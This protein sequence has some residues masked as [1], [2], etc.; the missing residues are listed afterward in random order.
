[1]VW[2][3]VSNQKVSKRSV[4]V[5]ATEILFPKFCHLYDDVTVQLKGSHVIG[6]ALDNVVIKDSALRILQIIGV[7]CDNRRSRPLSVTKK[8]REHSI[9]KA[10]DS[11]EGIIVK[12]V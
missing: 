3:L 7:H 11:M 5:K 2:R 6:I 9:F 4:Q 10:L 1:L 8:Y 12:S